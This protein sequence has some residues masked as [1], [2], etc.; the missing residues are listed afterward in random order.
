MT[1]EVK[2]NKLAY[3]K[4]IFH[5]LKYPSSNVIGTWRPMQESSQDQRKKQPMLILYSIL[6]LLVLPFK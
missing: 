5:S 2:I 6:R 3:T 1:P 4:A